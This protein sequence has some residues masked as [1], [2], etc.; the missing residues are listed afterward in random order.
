MFKQNKII[1][2]WNNRSDEWFKMSNL[3]TLFIP[4][5]KI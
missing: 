5:L 1:D 4:R 2:D 3:L